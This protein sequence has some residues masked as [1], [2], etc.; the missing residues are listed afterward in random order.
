MRLIT[1]AKGIQPFLKTEHNKTT[2]IEGVYQTIMNNTHL[3]FTKQIFKDKDLI[4]LFFVTYLLQDRNVTPD[5]ISK[6]KN[7]L[8]VFTLFEFGDD[9]NHISCE[10]CGGDG[11]VSC[12]ECYGGATTCS[13]CDGEGDVTCSECD[14]DGKD[15]DGE[16]CDECGGSGQVS[17]DN[18]GA[19][20]DVSCDN[21]GGTSQEDC[22]ECD[23]S[24]EIRVDDRIPFTIS[25][26]VSYDTNL[27]NI[28]EQKILRNEPIFDN[29]IVGN[30]SILL[31]IHYYEANEDITK[32]IDHNLKNTEHVGEILEDF[33]IVPR[34][35]FLTVHGIESVPDKFI[36]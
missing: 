6:I 10:H 27:K 26:Y 18:C 36:D 21:C 24:G 28:L 3:N 22:W 2:T 5:I 30:K 7:N 11:Q 19:N 1:I 16:S 34:A 13:E 33:Q 8:F 4:L 17:C 14:G 15:L 35:K 9:I 25:V 20:G 32:E 31:K 23:G 12:T 29:F